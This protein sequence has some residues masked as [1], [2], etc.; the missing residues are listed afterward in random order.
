MTITSNDGDHPMVTINE[1][2][3]KKDRDLA[4]YNNGMLFT[5]RKTGLLNNN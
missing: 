5:I 1:E 4:G 2:A 3:I